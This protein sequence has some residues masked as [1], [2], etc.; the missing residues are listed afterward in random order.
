MKIRRESRN[1]EDILA[2]KSKYESALMRKANVVGVGVGIPIRDDEAV[3]EIGIIVNVT[4]K[5]KA[6]KLAPKDLIPHNLEGIRVWVEEIGH[7]HAQK[8]S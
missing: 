8:E 7:P 1:L 2:V 3:S 5:V 4:H 6:E